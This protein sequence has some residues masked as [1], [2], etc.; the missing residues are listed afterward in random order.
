[1]GSFLGSFS[2][3]LLDRFTH[4][5]VIASGIVA[6]GAGIALLLATSG[7]G[8]PALALTTSGISTATVPLIPTSA[9]PTITNALVY[10]GIAAAASFVAGVFFGTVTGRFDRVKVEGPAKRA[11]EEAGRTITKEINKSTDNISRQAVNNI[12]ANQN[13]HFDAMEASVKNAVKD[14]MN[15]AKSEII[16]AVVSELHRSSN[17]QQSNIAEKSIKSDLPSS[18]PERISSGEL[19]KPEEQTVTLH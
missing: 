14:S 1:M 16:S 15:E 7:I 17:A 6:I 13:E 11:A 3:R 12:K 10:S 9:I 4:L 18:N 19:A 2:F 5:A 8:F